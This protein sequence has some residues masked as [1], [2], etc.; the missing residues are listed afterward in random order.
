MRVNDQ[1]TNCSNSGAASSFTRPKNRQIRRPTRQHRPRRQLGDRARMYGG[2]ALALVLDNS[3]SNIARMHQPSQPG[4]VICSIYHLSEVIE[5]ADVVISVLGRSDMLSF[6]DVGSRQVLRLAFDD[7][8]ASS[9]R[10]I[11][12]TR[13]QIIELID[14]VRRWN[15]TGTLLVHCRAGSSR[16]PA[17]AMIAAAALDRPDSAE[18]VLRIRTAKS[19]FRPN[20]AM[21]RFADCLLGPL[22][23]LVGLA[24]SAPLSTRNDPW[25]AVR[26]P[27]IAGRA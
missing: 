22:P 12:P 9:E 24:R 26:V 25:G 19:Y 21:L 13:E 6:P 3:D 4:I 5:Q 16:S 14:F 10:F 23:G 27:L 15:G 17:A 7:T 20:E 1:L 18:L 11:A 8:I 2:F